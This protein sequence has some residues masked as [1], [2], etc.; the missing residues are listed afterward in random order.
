VRHNEAHGNVI[1]IEAENSVD[2]AIYDNETWDNTCG[3]LVVG[4]PG[5]TKKITRSTSVHDNFIHDNNRENFGDQSTF[6]ATVPRGSGIVIASADETHVYNNTLRGNGS[7][8]ILV[9]SWPTIALLGNLSTDDTEFDQFSETTYIHDNRFE[10]NGSAPAAVYTEPPLELTL[11]IAGILWDGFVDPAKDA[12]T[13][14]ARKLCLQNNVGASFLNINA[15]QGPL[16]DVAA[17]DCSYAPLAPV[18]L[19]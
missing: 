19:Q 17:H 16:T 3:I 2:V 14:A 13:A 9:V 12:A 1:G 11:P 10:N 5:L 6:V 7:P 18:T 15:L 8:G 4:L